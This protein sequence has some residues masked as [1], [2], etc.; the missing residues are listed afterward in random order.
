MAVL[1]II[2]PSVR[3]VRLIASLHPDFKKQLKLP[4][5]INCLGLLTTARS[6]FRLWMMRGSM[7]E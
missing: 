1:D 6:N 7:S 5:H 2:K 3:A 4:D